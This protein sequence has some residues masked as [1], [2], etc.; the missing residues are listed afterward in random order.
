[1][2]NQ[3]SRTGGGPAGRRQGILAQPQELSAGGNDAVPEAPDYGGDQADDEDSL[4]ANYNSQEGYAS[5]RADADFGD[6]RDD[7]M[8]GGTYNDIDD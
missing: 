6:D 3:G 4:E 2:L 1:M 8:Q 7:I 5:D